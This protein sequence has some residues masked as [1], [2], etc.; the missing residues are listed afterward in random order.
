VVRQSLWY[1][2]RVEKD[3]ALAWIIAGNLFALA[4]VHFTNGGLILLLW[5]Y[6][7][8]SVVIGWYAQKRMRALTEFSTDGLKINDQPVAPTTKTAHQTANFFVL[9]YGFFHFGYFVFLMVFSLTANAQG[10]APVTV[11]D[12]PTQF[13]VGKL[14]A[15]DALFIA[16]IAFSFVKG[17]R[18][19]HEEQVASDVGA[20]RNLGTLMA[21]PYLRIIPM[22]LTIILGAVLGTGGGLLLFGVLK[23]LADVGMHAVER[24][25]LKRR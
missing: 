8:Q 21:F 23:T 1:V 9:H 25:W 5:P 24:R 15:L 13:F 2:L 20:R 7:A 17:Q 6:W 18:I 16:A 22:H 19:E 14:D 3:R 11:N 10:F 4:T 12:V